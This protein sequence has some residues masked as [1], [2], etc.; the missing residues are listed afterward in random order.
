MLVLGILS[1]E[2]AQKILSRRLFRWLGKISYSVYLI[3]IPLLFSLSTGIFLWTEGTLGYLGS[4]A[5]SFGVSL[6]VLIALAWLYHRFVEMGLAR[7]QDRLFSRLEK[8]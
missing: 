2:G 3:H 5:L 7:L 8:K 4:A 6:V 1:W